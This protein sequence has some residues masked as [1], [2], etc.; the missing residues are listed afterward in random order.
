MKRAFIPGTKQGYIEEEPS[1]VRLFY[2]C[3]P[4]GQH[5]IN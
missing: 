3:I 1:F 5:K 2:V 4:N